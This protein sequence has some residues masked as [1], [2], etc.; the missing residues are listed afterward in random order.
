[1]PYSTTEHQQANQ[2]PARPEKSAGLPASKPVLEERPD[3]GVELRKRFPIGTKMSYCGVTMAVRITQ[4][5][6]NGQPA[7]GCDYNV[8]GAIHS[9]AFTGDELQVFGR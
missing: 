3:P 5:L 7:V 6:D 1:M 9:I 4:I 8:N 2:R